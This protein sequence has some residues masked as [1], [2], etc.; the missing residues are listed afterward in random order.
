M[1]KKSEKYQRLY[2][3]L[4]PLL[5]NSPSLYAQMSTINAVLYHKMSNFFWIGFYFIKNNELIVGPYQGPLACQ[6]LPNPKGVCWHAVIN[7]QPVTVPNVEAFPDH[8]ACDSRSKSELVE[9]IYN[10]KDEII[11]VLDI[12]SNK[13]DQ[14]DKDDIDGINTILTLLKS[15]FKDSVII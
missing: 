1:S 10:S 2:N 3:Q 13:L 5:E 4:K 8:I 14:F 7:R 12:D 15:E 11:A 9:L 6:I